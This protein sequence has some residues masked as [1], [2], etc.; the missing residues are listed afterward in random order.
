MAFRE[1]KSIEN[2]SKNEVGQK[3][4]PGVDVHAMWV[5]LGPQKGTQNLITNHQ[6]TNL[7]KGTQQYSVLERLGRVWMAWGGPE[8]G[9]PGMQGGRLRLGPGSQGSLY[10][11]DI[12]T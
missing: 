6:K 11:L 2:Q 7:K 12:Y 10:I 3:W 5:D 8:R 1:P 4:R 9:D